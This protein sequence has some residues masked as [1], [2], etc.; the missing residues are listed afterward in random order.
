MKTLFAL[1]L[2]FVFSTQVAAQD[3]IYGEKRERH[4]VWRKSGK[5]KRMSYNPYLD[6]KGK[7]KPS[8]KMARE[9]KKY[10]KRSNRE[11][12]KQMRHSKKGLGKKKK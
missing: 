7:N 9:D 6:R 8:S 5:K 11:A 1:L 2:F 3:Q 12:K 10:I 4:K